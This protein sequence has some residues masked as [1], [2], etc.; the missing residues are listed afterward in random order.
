M[1]AKKIEAFKGFSP[2]TIRFFKDLAANNYKE[3][4]DAHKSVYD[5]EVVAPL[6]SLIT[7]LTPT[8]YNIDPAFELRPHRAMS[9]IYRDVRFSKNKDPYKTCMWITFQLPV[10]RDDWKD[11]P[12]YFMEINGDN[13]ILGMGLFMP[14]KKVMDVFREE[15]SFHAEEFRRVTQETV[16]DRGFLLGGDE[17]KRPLANDLPEYHQ[18]WIQRKGIYVYKTIPIGNEVFS[19]EFADRLADDFQALEWLYKFMKECQP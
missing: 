14:K 19:V 6:K 10:S 5:N 1:A 15:V 13:Y 3:W 4:F 17:Y 11:Y 9:R 8:M 12:G 7:Y 18:Q 2:E 16:L